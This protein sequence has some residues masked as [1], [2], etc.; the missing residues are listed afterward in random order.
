MNA[1]DRA[2]RDAGGVLNADAR[3]GNKMR[4]LKLLL[5]AT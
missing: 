1:V 4:H 2:D 3:L 5:A